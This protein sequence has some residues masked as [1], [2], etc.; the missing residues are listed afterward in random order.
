M[1][2]PAALM[3]PDRYQVFLMTSPANGPLAFAAH[4]WFVV[5]RMGE[6]SRWE[7]TFQKRHRSLSWGHLNKDLFPFFSGIE[8]FPYLPRP[9]W[10][11]RCLGLLEGGEDS[12]AKRMADL[13]VDSLRAY[14][15]VNTYS[16]LGPNSNTYAQWV[17]D[18]FPE[19]GW[20]LPWNAFG[21][22]GR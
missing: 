8:V 13:I 10:K 20:Q 1:R 7:I 12:D 3:R 21:K 16:L 5:N 19:C 11:G 2:D 9:L 14:P 4:A 18:K 22:K 17:I 15:Y 6:L